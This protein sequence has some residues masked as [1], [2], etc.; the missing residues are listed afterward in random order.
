[1]CLFLYVL[2]SAFKSQVHRRITE[3]IGL[4]G[5][6]GCH[7][8]L[9][10]SLMHQGEK[11]GMRCCRCWSRYLTAACGTD[12]QQSREKC[13]E[14]GVAERSCCVLATGPVPHPSVL[15]GEVGR[16]RSCG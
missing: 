12:P 8:V 2:S 10:T 6:F 13:G 11:K 3:D 1:M 14:G 5:T 16:Y 4:E 15:L 9:P 7:Q